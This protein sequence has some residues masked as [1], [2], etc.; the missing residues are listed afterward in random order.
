LPSASPQ[1]KVTEKTL[2]NPGL[3]L[4]VEREINLAST[5]HSMTLIID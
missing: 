2:G 5:Q 3:P 1:S 4:E